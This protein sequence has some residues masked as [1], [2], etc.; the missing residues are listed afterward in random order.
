MARRRVEVTTRTAVGH[1]NPKEKIMAAA[2]WR[3]P[4]MLMVL[5]LSFMLIVV[6]AVRT[7]IFAAFLGGL[8][9]ATSAGYILRNRSR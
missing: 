1:L 9:M 8:A 5:L 2:E 6:A 4:I 3:M 7:D